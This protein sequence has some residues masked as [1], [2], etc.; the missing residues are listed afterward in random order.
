VTQEFFSQRELQMRELKLV[1]TYIELSWLGDQLRR[2]SK[3][4]VTT[5]GVFDILHVGHVRY[6]EQAKALGDVLVLGLNSDE[7]VREIR[8]P[9]RPLIPE[10][11]R[12]EVLLALESVDYVFIF[13]ENH[14]EKFLRAITPHIHVKGGAHP[15]KT[16][17][18]RMIVEEL[19]G[20]MRALP[21]FE[22]RSTTGIIETILKR[23]LKV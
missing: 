17:R 23:Y 15:L 9:R 2:E 18:S 22:G 6:L 8:D 10:A 5:N 11:E 12:A 20:E 16:S 13:G 3:I 1:P 7:S 19:G 21:L 14:P 4:V